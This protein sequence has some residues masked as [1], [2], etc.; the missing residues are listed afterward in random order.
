MKKIIN[1]Q[2]I[3]KTFAAVKDKITVL[4]DISVAIYE[5][6]FVSVMGPSGSGKSTLLYTLS[7]M[8][9][10]DH[11]E[12]TFNGQS[13]TACGET[14]LA[15]IRR[16]QMGFVFQQPTFLKNLAIIDNIVLPAL[17]DNRKKGKELAN[18]A[19]QLLEK[20]GIG[21][22][23]YRMTNQVSGGQLQ[24]AEICRALINEP[25]MIFADE[26]TGALNSRSAEEIMKNFLQINQQGRTILLVT[27]DA[28]VAAQS[29]RVL[30]M[31]DG[32]IVDELHLGK[33]SNSFLEN[34]TEKVTS[35]MLKVEM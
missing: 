9:T 3:H 33:L 31:K 28:K 35:K 24:R 5:G 7:G 23:A 26:P 2:H 27:H 21:D 22:L 30:F 15:D 20:T 25:K 32:Q 6:E 1:G 14:E 12:I 17:R 34:R 16:Q 11:G 13:L 10:I 18:K 29:E 8:D 19:K 4:E